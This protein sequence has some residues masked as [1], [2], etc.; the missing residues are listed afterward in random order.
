MRGSVLLAVVLAACASDAGRPR[1]PAAGRAAGAPPPAPPFAEL[2]ANADGVIDGVEFAQLTRRLF[3]RLDA[4]GDGN[5]SAGEYARFQSRPSGPPPRG[6]PPGM[7]LSE[8][9]G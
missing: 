4:D 5:L 2:D 9:R 7:P 6:R 3:V 8:A 1:P